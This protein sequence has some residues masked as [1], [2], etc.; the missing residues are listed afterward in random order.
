MPRITNET[1]NYMNKS[2]KFQFIRPYTFERGKYYI[3]R[4]RQLGSG[5]KAPSVV[6]FIAYDAC[7]AWVIIQDSRGLKMRCLREDIFEI[8]NDFHH[9]ACHQQL[10]TSREQ[11]N[12]FNIDDRH[13][14]WSV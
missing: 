2:P 11:S 8:N 4:E 14:N 13:L 7:P 1:L 5:R 6:K 12:I 9:H 10:S 3:F